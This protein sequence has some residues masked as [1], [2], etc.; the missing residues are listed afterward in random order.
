[1][2]HLVFFRLLPPS[3]SR[4]RRS[5]QHVREDN[6][7][8]AS[9]T[10]HNENRLIHTFA[11]L[12]GSD[13][14]LILDSMAKTQSLIGPVGSI[15]MNTF[16]GKDPDL[17]VQKVSFVVSARDGSPPLRVAEAMTVLRL[18]LSQKSWDWSLVKREYPY[19][20]DLPLTTT[21]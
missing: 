1:M 20:F 6:I 11:L 2:V 21:D 10:L 9:F 17:I 18:N 7:R 5:N 19:L 13:T 8:V 12:D 15:R 16:H 4:R 3:R 14:S